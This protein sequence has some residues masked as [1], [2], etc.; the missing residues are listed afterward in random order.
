MKEGFFW[1]NLIG[2]IGRLPI[3]TH[4]QERNNLNMTRVLVLKLCTVEV[5]DPQVNLLEEEIICKTIVGI[6][7]LRHRLIPDRTRATKYSVLLVLINPLRL[8]HHLGVISIVIEIVG[9][10]SVPSLPVVGVVVE[11]DLV[12]EGV[13]AWEF[14]IGDLKGSEEVE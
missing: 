12:E 9:L 6:R 10:V 4:Y 14:N 1:E 7:L 2:Q 13:M 5:K 3:V 8:H 11:V